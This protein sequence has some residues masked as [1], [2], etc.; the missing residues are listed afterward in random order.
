MLALTMGCVWI[1]V[2]HARLDHGLCFLSY[3]LLPILYS[4]WSNWGGMRGYAVPPKIMLALQHPYK[5]IFRLG[6]PPNE[7]HF[8]GLFTFSLSLKIT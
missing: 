8:Q 1:Y 7:N 3:I 2:N 4:Q 5:Y 6:H